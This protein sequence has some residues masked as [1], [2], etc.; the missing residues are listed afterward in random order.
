MGYCAKYVRRRRLVNFL[1]VRRRACFSVVNELPE[2]EP[3]TVDESG[4]VGEGGGR[5]AVLE[6]SREL[7]IRARLL[8][9]LLVTP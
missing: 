1:P 9:I 3:I 8:E 2:R 5:R 7:H 6:D 4:R